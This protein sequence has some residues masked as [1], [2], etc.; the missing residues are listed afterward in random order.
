MLQLRRGKD[1]LRQFF[2][3][4]SNKVIST[5]SDFTYMELQKGKVCNLIKHCLGFSNDFFVGEYSR[6]QSRRRRHYVVNP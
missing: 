1:T 6:N 2:E 5:N 4:L 3:F